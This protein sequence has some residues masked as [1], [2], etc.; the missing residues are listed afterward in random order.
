MYRYMETAYRTSGDEFLV[1]SHSPKCEYYTLNIFMLKSHE[2]DTALSPD[3]EVN[4]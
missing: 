1:M 3:P 2:T 4:K